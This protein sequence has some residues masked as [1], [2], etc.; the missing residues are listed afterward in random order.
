[1]LKSFINPLLKGTSVSKGVALEPFLP[2]YRKEQLLISL[3]SIIE[4][5]ISHWFSFV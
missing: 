2:F 5:N 3:S 1:M 4:E